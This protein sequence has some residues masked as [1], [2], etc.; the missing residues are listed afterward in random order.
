[1]PGVTQ[2]NLEWWFQYH[3]PQ[4]DEQLLAYRAI[5]D[6][7]KEFAKVVLAFSPACADQTVAIRRIREAVM[8]ANAAIACD[9]K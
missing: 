9:G 4:G 2:E 6:A 7:G 5:R 1:M 8:N 3:A